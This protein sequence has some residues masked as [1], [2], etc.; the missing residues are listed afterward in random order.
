MSL[1][2]ARSYVGKHVRL[3]WQDRKG[4]NIEADCYVF[5]VAFVSVYGPCLITSEGDISL[6]RI[7]SCTE[8]AEQ[9]A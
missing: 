8:S 9:V 5:S 3:V 1:S 6:G 4:Q 2:E 7:V